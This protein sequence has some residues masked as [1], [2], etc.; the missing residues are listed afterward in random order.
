MDTYE[1]TGEAALLQV[2]GQFPMHT[3]FDVGSNTGSWC[4][5]AL[6]CLPEA[7]VHTFELSH[8]TYDQ[9]LQ[10]GLDFSRITC[11][12]FCLGTATQMV[13][14][15]YC[16]HNNKLSTQLEHMNPGTLAHVAYAWMSGLVVQGDAYAQS[17]Q[18]DQVNL[19]KIDVEG[20]EP[21]VLQGFTQMLHM[22]KIDVIQFEYGTANIIT[23]FLLM[24]F[25]KLLEPLGYHL[26]KLTPMGVDFKP[27]SLVDEDFRGPNYVAVHDSCAH[28]IPKLQS[29]DQA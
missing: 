25:Y 6:S 14:F 15:K 7:H 20:S 8:H 21:D 18:I 28:L 22:G 23:K 19:L 17:R 26:G 3:V 1:L 5:L 29:F 12:S 24:D 9:F 27:Y 4:A 13:Q 10:S 11:N 16:D 2:L